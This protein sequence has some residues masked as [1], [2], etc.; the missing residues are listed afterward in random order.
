MRQAMDC[1]RARAQAHRHGQPVPQRSGGRVEPGHLVPVQ[2]HAEGD[3]NLLKLLMSSNEIAPA[4]QKRSESAPA[5]PL[6]STKR[7][8][9][10]MDGFSVDVQVFVIEQYQHPTMLSEPPTRAAGP[11]GHVEYV[12]AELP[13]VL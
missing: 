1:R 13:G 3:L 9:S 6:L 5:W 7:S 10:A 11:E 2:M 8:R 12:L 4:R